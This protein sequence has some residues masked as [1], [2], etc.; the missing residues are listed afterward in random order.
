MI[1]ILVSRRERPAAFMPMTAGRLL[2]ALAAGVA[3]L[4]LFT[5]AALAQ[6]WNFVGSRIQGMGGAGVA[7]VDD[8]TAQ[9]W[10][11]A[12]LGFKKRGEWDVQLPITVNGS[13]ENKVLEDV[14]DLV[15]RFDDVEATIDQ[16][17]NGGGGLPSPAQIDET[18]SWLVDLN[19]L[20]D[21][22]ESVQGQ[23]AV[24][25]LGH[26]GNFG[27][28]AISN[29]TIFS[30]PDVDLAN[31]GFDT[32]GLDNLLLGVTPNAADLP[33][34]EGDIA[35]LG[36]FWNATK[37]EQFVD[38]FINSPNVDASDPDTQQF[39]LDIATAV[40]D[41]Q[42][43]FANN[44]SGVVAV[45][46]SLEEFGLSYGYALPM[47]F[48]KPFDK[49]LSI[50]AT[51]KYMMGIAF[52]RASLYTDG[53][54][55]GGLGD[56]EPFRDSTISHNFGLDLA[57][58]F[59]PFD[60]VRVGLVARNVNAPKFSA[61]DF[62]DI[63]VR[64]AVRLGAALTP[65][66]RLVLA[67]DVDLTENYFGVSDWK[68]PEPQ[69]RSRI[70]SLGS[71]YTVPLG[72]PCALALRFG[73]FTNMAG[74]VDS[75]WAMTGGLGLKLWGFWLDLSAGGSFEKE[76]IRTGEFEYVN[77]PDRLNAGLGLKWE[78]SI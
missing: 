6:Q 28:G 17:Q 69:F 40:N 31:L 20:G 49:K 51:A 34:L 14:S 66:E 43:D 23:V 7:T 1:E 22:G 15:V 27:F 24:G 16:L 2:A 57:L 30:Y 64:P 21:T 48:F 77:V 37:A 59:R 45:G 62:G 9:Y 18:I 58:D 29:T 8:S 5:P 47:P 60:F 54:S 10:N 73:G 39:M 65:I 35:S 46:L 38:A 25:L 32:A 3:V 19:E 55:G 44:T 74:D 76:R 63:R 56:I 36:G 52:A 67:M 11:P 26:V 72:K 53:V 68:G 61:G 12:A 75:S 41:N 13:I 42:F 71:E 78:K 50:G 33:V 4:G 70:I